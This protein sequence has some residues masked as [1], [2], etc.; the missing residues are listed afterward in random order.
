M[1]L[2]SLP[3]LLRDEPA[4]ASS[5]GQ[6]ERGPRR[7]RGRPPAHRRRA[8]PPVGAPP[9][10]G[11]LPDR[12]GGRAARRRPAAVLPDG[13]VDA[14]PGVGDAAVRA[15]QPQR[16]DD[17]PAPRG[18]VAAARPGAHAP[19]SSSPAC[20]RC[21]SASARRPPRSSPSSSGR[22]TVIDP[23]ELL[24]HPR[25][26]PATGARSWSSTAARSPGAARSSTCS[27]RPPTCRSASTCGAT[28]STGSPTFSV[29]DQRSTGDLDEALI[30]PARELL[31]DRRGPR[32]RRRP[33]RRGAVGPRAVGAPGRG[34]AVRRHGELAAV[35]HRRRR[36]AH[37]PA[38]RRPPRWSWSSRGAC[39]TGP[40]TCSPRR[41]TSP[42]RWPARGAATPTSRF[43]RLHAEPTACSAAA[44]GAGR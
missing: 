39:A 26:S 44:V 10:R 21:C 16:R 31:P 42:A 17:G 43:P 11:G 4:L 27:R 40:T 28:R 18:P 38:A 3:P 12:D 36:A 5:L 41:T 9:A 33:G 30:F 32:P 25:R 19:R 24:T 8:R 14:V 23:D 7:A 34:P 13:E 1:R 29:N 37:R 6:P 20:A 35:A 2:A 22:A 15:G